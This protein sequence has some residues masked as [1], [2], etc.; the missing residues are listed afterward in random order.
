MK[1]LHSSTITFFALPVK[2]LKPIDHSGST[3]AGPARG[4]PEG[5]RLH[6][7]QQY[8]RDEI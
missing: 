4:I 7:I 1:I 8:V 3:A 5:P 6:V 2:P